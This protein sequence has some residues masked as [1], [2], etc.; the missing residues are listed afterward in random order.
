MLRRVIAAALVAVAVHASTS[1]A[2]QAARSFPT[3]R[4][5]VGVAGEGRLIEQVADRTLTAHRIYVNESEMP[6]GSMREAASRGEL[7]IVT[8]KRRGHTWSNTASGGDD[9]YWRRQANQ[10]ASWGRPV[11]L[12][13][14]H[15]ADTHD[16]EVY[17]TPAAYQAAFRHVEGILDAAPNVRTIWN[18]TGYQ[19]A[20]RA[21]LFYPGD[22]VVDYVSTD[23]YSGCPNFGS[24]SSLAGETHAPLAFAQAHRKPLIFAEWAEYANWTRPEYISDA[25]AYVANHPRIKAVL[26]FNHDFRDVGHCDWRLQDTPSLSAFAALMAHPRFF[27]PR[28]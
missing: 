8:V 24:P 7:P 17:G 12:G 10:L 2:A 4:A 20:Q 23:P 1:S 26:W 28:I 5:Y 6:T 16:N 27:A 18:L 3:D 19:F 9:A 21:P 22:D 13:Y 15:E 14:W 25:T 11:V